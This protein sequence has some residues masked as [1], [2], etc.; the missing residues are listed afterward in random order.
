MTNVLVI[1]G[2]PIGSRLAGP[3]I[4][5]WNISKVLSESNDVVLLTTGKL[6]EAIEAPFGLRYLR[7]GS[8]REFSALEQW[9]DVILFQGYALEQFKTL[10]E[11]SKIVVADIYDPLQ[12]EVLEQGRSLPNATWEVKVAEARRVMNQQLIFAD[13]LLCSSER[14]KLFYIGQLAALGRLNPQNYGADSSLSQMIE[15]VPFGLDA[16]PPKMSRDAIREHASR[17]GPDD[18]ILIWG[19]GIYEWFDPKTLIRAVANLSSSGKHVCLY[20]LGTKH[21]RLEPMGIVAESI[22]LAEELG[23]LDQSVFFNENWVDYRERADYL[24]GAN[25]GVSTHFSSLETTLSFRTRILDYLWAG[26]PMIVTEG[27]VFSELVKKEEMGQV[28]KEGDVLG[29]SKAIE[30]VLYDEELVARF[31]KNVKR[32]REQY[33]WPTV[34]QPLVDF[35]GSPRH[36]PDFENRNRRKVSELAKSQR[37]YGIWHNIRMTIHYL[38]VSGPKA[39]VSRVSRKLKDNP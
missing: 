39:T 14:Q 36:A 3:A 17:I 11:S 2:D 35:V 38:K 31:R 26:L 34:L 9:A 21:P 37:A 6:D 10:R 30:S 27:D 25:A 20:F 8:E 12:L 29:L 24:L 23:V 13:Y 4:R 7:P 32:V 16:V 5:A 28:V 33:F 1:T 18:K 22:A 19:G 15:V